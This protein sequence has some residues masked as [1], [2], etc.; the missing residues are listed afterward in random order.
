[1]L[2]A[3]SAFVAEFRASAG[4]DWE[5]PMPGLVRKARS[6]LSDWSDRLGR[7]TNWPQW[8]MLWVWTRGWLI[9]SVYAGINETIAFHH[10]PIPAIESTIFGAILLVGVTWFSVWI[11]RRPRGSVRDLT[12]VVFSALGIWALV[13]GL[14][15]GIALGHPAEFVDFEDQFFSEYPL[16]GQGGE[17][18]ENIYAFDMEGNPI[19]VVLFDQLGRPLLTMPP[20]VYEDAELRPRETAVEYPGGYVIF[21]RDEFGRIIPNLYPLELETYN[22]WGELQPRQPP[23]AWSA[24]GDASAEGTT[25][26]TT[27]ARFGD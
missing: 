17:P 15:G 12:S 25:P 23:G 3:P 11:D 14:L 26:P 10:F 21:A 1:M 27:T 13:V 20:W 5:R 6:R 19:E 24:P 8:R 4:L 18:V 16:I 7:L 9:L 22:D 2:G